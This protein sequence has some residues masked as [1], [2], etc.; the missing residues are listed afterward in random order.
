MNNLLEEYKLE[1]DLFL[2]EEEMFNSLIQLGSTCINESV[3]LISINEGF[4]ETIGK[5]IE[6]IWV[7]LQKAWT[8]F[9]EIVKNGPSIAFLKSIEKKMENPEPNGIIINNHYDYN[10]SKID[11]IKIIPF[12]YEQMKDSLGSNSDFE[13]KYYSQYKVND[14]SLKESIISTSYTILD[15]EKCTSEMLK[16]MYSFCTKDFLPAIDKLENEMKTMETNKKNITNLVNSINPTQATK[17]SF[18]IYESY[19]HEG[20]EEKKSTSFENPSGAGGDNSQIVTHV[21]T[22]LSVSTDIISAKMKCYR[23]AYAYNIKVIRN[24]I[25]PATTK[26]EK[27]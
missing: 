11:G 6:K 17:E 4:K 15:K 7:A 22:Y 5:Y 18:A 23:D 25:K 19:I 26:K 12:N 20:E 21:K 13:S 16:N 14:K 27:E 10:L 9:K 8:R 2:A 1:Y 24:Y 3:G